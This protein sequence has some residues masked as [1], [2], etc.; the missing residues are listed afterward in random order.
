MP[1]RQHSLYFGMLTVV[2]AFVG[3]FGWMRLRHVPSAAR[4]DGGMASSA[5]FGDVPFW[6]A[7]VVV[8]YVCALGAFTPFYKLVY[9]LPFGDTMRCPVKFVHLVEFCAAALA[10]YGI[11]F[12]RAKFEPRAAWAAG[13]LAVLAAVNVFDLARVDARYLAVQD[14]S[15][16]RARNDVA[17]D[18]T[19]LGGGSVF[20]ALAP[21]EGARQIDEAL[22]CNHVKTVRDAKGA[23]FL[24]AGGSAFR[25]DSS[26]DERMRSGRLKVAGAYSVSRGRGVRRTEVRGASLLLLQDVSVPAPDPEERRGPTGGGAKRVVGLLSLF[27]T[28]VVAACGA[29]RAV[30]GIVDGWRGK[31]VAA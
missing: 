8:S 13:T 21:Q 18:V 9:A 2:F 7:A 20:V 1:Y 15:F 22:S 30:C 23:R 19:G 25:T 31:G 27:A 4:A 12:L 16:S 11:E 6:I 14:V 28:V 17:E 3:A 29:T 5:D 10:G 26:L 24:L